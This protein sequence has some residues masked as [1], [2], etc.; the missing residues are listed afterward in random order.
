MRDKD[1]KGGIL[2]MNNHTFETVDSGGTRGRPFVIQREIDE[3]G[4]LICYRVGYRGGHYFT[5]EAEAYAYCLGRGLL[6]GSRTPY[7]WGGSK[8]VKPEDRGV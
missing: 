1:V 4:R 8:Y 5:T 6:A 3:Q 2:G 7:Q